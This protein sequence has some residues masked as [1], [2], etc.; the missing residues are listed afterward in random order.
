MAFFFRLLGADQLALI[1]YGQ[2]FNNETT[3]ELQTV[4][5]N[6]ERYWSYDRSPPVYPNSTGNGTDDWNIAYEQARTLVAQMTNNE[7]NN[8]TYSFQ[9]TSN[10]CSGN[11]EAVPRLG[12]PGLHVGVAWNPD[13]A[14]KRGQYMGAEFK[15]KSIHIAVGPVMGP[16][17]RVARGGGNWEGFS[18]DHYLCGKL[19]YETIIGMQEFIIASVNHLV[20]N[21]QETDR[22]PSVYLVNISVSSNINNRTMHNLYLWPFQD[23]VK[24]GVG[25]VMC[26]YNRVNNSHACHNSKVL[27]GLLNTELGFQGYALTDWYAQHTGVAS[28]NAGLD[29][30]MPLA[31]SNG[32]MAQL[33]LDDMATRIVAT[34]YNFAKIDSPGANVPGH[35]LVKVKAALPLKK[36]KILSLSG[37][38]ATAALI[39]SQ[40]PAFAFQQGL[41]GTLVTG[42]GS[43]SNTAAYIDALFNT[44]Q[45]Q[46]KLDGV[47]LSWDL[48]SRIRDSRKV[49]TGHIEY[50]NITAVIYAHVPGQDSVVLPYTGAKDPG[51][52]ATLL[53]PVYLDNSSMYYAQSNLTEGGYINY[54]HYITNNLV[55][56]YKFGYRLIYST[57]DYR[58]LRVQVLDLAWKS[59]LPPGSEFYNTTEPKPPGGLDSLWDEVATVSFTVTNTGVVDAAEVAQLVLRVFHKQTI[60]LGK[61]LDLHFHLTR[62]DLSQWGVVTQ[63]WVLRQGIYKAMIGKTVLDIY[64]WKE[65]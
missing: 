34:W 53:N 60:R 51:D 29:M 57:F 26:S 59:Y 50:P 8:I 28:T 23:T 15:R 55:P 64:G 46:A 17:A 10:G 27:N 19:A 32:S 39:N 38:D 42:D 58:D 40:T 54:R 4:L 21:E 36:P 20:S 3:G 43:G 12:F 52:Y 45:C 30:S 41:G 63:Q 49:G 13:L 9:S 35:V 5:R 24:A 33:R 47:Y 14:R 56:R 18:S 2:T 62:R 22:N 48:F 37:Y 31:D 6:L 16:L 61:S 65:T 11:L 1:V 25:P 7:K 44:F